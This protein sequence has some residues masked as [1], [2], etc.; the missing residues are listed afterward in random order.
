MTT[1]K[2]SSTNSKTTANS[3]E[4]E[5]VKGLLA[6][7]REEIES[8]RER[9]EA[10]QSPPAAYGSV[11]AFNDD[12]DTI[13]VFAN[14]SVTR[15]VYDPELEISLGD[16]V[17]LNPEMIVVGVREPSQVFGQI[18]TVDTV[19]DDYRVIVKDEMDNEAVVEKT[20][21]LKLRTGDRVRMGA[22]DTRRIAEILPSQNL[23]DL[24]LSETPN[25][26]YEDIGGLEEQIEKIRDAIELPVLHADLFQKYE[27]RATKGVLLYGPPGTGKTLLAKAVA[28]SL[29]E[30]SRF[31]NIKGPELLNKWVGET[32]S[33]IRKLFSDAK[34]SANEGNPV[35][36][37]FD[38]IESLFRTR[39]SGVSSDM[40]STIVPQ[41]LAE[42]DG[43]EELKNVIVIGAS[44]RQDLIDPAVL[45]PGR[46]DVKIRID[47]PDQKGTKDIFNKHLS[48][49][50]PVNGSREQIVDKATEFIFQESPEFEFVEITYE[51]GDRE[52]LYY[53]DFISG[54]VIEGIVNRAKK[55][56]IKRELAGGLEGVSIDDMLEAVKQ[57]FKEHE[58]LPNTSTP[59]EWSKISGKKGEKIVAVRSLVSKTDKDSRPVI[60][61]KAGQGQYL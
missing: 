39:G 46:L 6:D 42:L 49:V 36:I 21:D 27:H 41:F 19:L 47:R 11:V 25:V 48:D 5:K 9:L 43:V 57:E 10:Y 28:Y 29:G 55:I 2:N 51:K 1:P 35:V 52:T 58:D 12:D 54:A 61:T 8:L 53:K 45:R 37:F 15:V 30:N 14:G 4:D 40:E 31:Y 24:I 20:A 17:W 13:D 50:V 16:E 44:N 59:D 38:E 33:K 60:D 7:A 26:S 23:Q 18:A 3:E 32:E 22:I 34:E 56:T